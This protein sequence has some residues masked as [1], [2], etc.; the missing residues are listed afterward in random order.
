MGIDTDE[1]E[2]AQRFL[3]YVLDDVDYMKRRGYNPTYFLGMIRQHGSAVTVARLL[4]S[5]S[6]HTLWVRA[7]VGDGRARAQHRV[8]RPAPV[9]HATIHGR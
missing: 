5:S 6:R 1:R 9:V 7:V 8:R 2:L 4:L 3:Q